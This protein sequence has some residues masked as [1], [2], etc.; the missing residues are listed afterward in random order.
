[1]TTLYKI[2]K[3]RLN[4]PQ[5]YL[6]IASKNMLVSCSE[7]ACDGVTF[8]GKW[9]TDP[10]QYQDDDSFKLLVAKIE[11]DADEPGQK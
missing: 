4:A 6:M 11:N 2:V 8:T 7:D 10:K 9:T 3:S 1:M 5:Q